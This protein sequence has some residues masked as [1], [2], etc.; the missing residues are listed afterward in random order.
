MISFRRRKNGRMNGGGRWIADSLGLSLVGDLVDGRLH[1]G[2]AGS[3]VVFDRLHLAVQF[4]H[5]RNSCSNT[6]T[7]RL[8]NFCLLNLFNY[9]VLGYHRRW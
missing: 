2:I 4:V 7:L 3:V 5:Q 9:V 6:H 8:F 1:F